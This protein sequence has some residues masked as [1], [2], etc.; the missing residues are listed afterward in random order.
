MEK[1]MNFPQLPNTDDST[2]LIKKVEPILY[3]DERGGF[4][5][6]Y[7]AESSETT[8]FIIKQ[9]SVSISKRNVF[10]GLHFQYDKPMAKGMRVVTN[11]VYM[12]AMDMRPNSPVFGKT[13]QFWAPGGQ[14]IYYAPAYIARGFLT[15]ADDTMVEY[16]HD[17]IYQQFSTWTISFREL[18]TAYVPYLEKTA[19]MNHRDKNEGTYLRTWEDFARGHNIF[20]DV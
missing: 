15:V 18:D 13:V 10:R 8:E 7:S 17:E 19:I 12:F 1:L 4:A 5:Q 14:T 2:K 6:L 16:F 9:V 20:L 11:G 3:E